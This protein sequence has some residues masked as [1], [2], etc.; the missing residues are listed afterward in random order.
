[1]PRKTNLVKCLEARGLKVE[2]VPGWSTRGS[3]SFN[4]KGVMAHWTAGPRN[5]K[6]RPSLRVVTNGR[7]G[8][9]GPLC[10]V[11]LDRVG[12]AV[13]VAAGRANHGGNGVWK[14]AKGNSSFFGVEAEAADGDDWTDAQRESYPKVCAAL[15]DA[16]K[17][18]D[19][20]WVCGH[21]EYALPKGRKI[22]INGYTTAEL[23][24]QVAQVLD[25]KKV[26]PSKPK[27]KPKP[28]NTVKVKANSGNSK[29]SNIAIA[30]MLNSIGFDAGYPDGVPG[31]RLKAG[32]M[33]YQKS[34]E[35]YPG[36]KVDG[37][38][39]PMTQKHYEWVRDDLQPMLNK[40]SASQR[41]S[42]LAC[43]G[44]YAKLVRKCIIAVQTDNYK[45][46]VKAG[47]YYKDGLA[48]PITC[49]FLGIKKHPNA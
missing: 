2:Y 1:M 33:A 29:A 45:L 23:R 14:G 26:T 15:L 4:P 38:W 41:V 11:Y 37:D 30:K 42:L 9:P 19:A 34:Q 25:G 10:N 46:Y 39:G 32:V 7:P 17:Q 44:S 49:K 21:S 48:G 36:M 8:L 47:G 13:V 27:P 6:G 35:Y 20:S 40:W 16:I 12:V 31:T 24:K 22:D 18:S 3:S 43:D 5:S 28:E